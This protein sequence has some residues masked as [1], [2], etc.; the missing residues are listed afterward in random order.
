MERKL[1]VYAESAVTVNLEELK[2]LEEFNEVLEKY[3]CV[4]VTE[5][6]MKEFV[7]V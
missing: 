2:R 1:K 5:I 4:G 7:V 6:H 3:G